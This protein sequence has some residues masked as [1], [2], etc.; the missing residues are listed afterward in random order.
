MCVQS[1]SWKKNINYFNNISGGVHIKDIF[2][3]QT[4]L[5]ETVGSLALSNTYLFQE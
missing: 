4:Y 1:T 2:E 3:K 5:L